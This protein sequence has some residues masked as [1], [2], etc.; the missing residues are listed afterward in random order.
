VPLGYEG[1]S[2]SR[3]RT[4]DRPTWNNNSRLMSGGDDLA[5]SDDRSILRR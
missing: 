1:R 5:S 3:Q 2:S 4:T